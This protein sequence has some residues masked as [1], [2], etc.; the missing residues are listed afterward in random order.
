MTSRKGL[1]PTQIVAGAFTAIILLGTFLLWLPI[2]AAQGKTTGF[3]DALFTSTSAV[4]VTGLG[5]LDTETHWSM[6]GHWV[7]AVLIQV[8]GLE[9]WD[10]QAWLDIYLKAES[11]LRTK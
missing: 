1:H 9:S 2:S 11:R 5:T 6:F 10:S 4:T 7:I 8:G 3:M